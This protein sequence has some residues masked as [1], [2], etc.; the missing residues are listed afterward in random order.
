MKENLEKAKKGRAGKGRTDL[1]KALFTTAPQFR[2]PAPGL[3]D[4]DGSEGGRR[5]RHQ[6]QGPPGEPMGVQVLLGT[7]LKKYGR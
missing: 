4:G 7:K 1:E 2:A 6:G 5:R 3:H